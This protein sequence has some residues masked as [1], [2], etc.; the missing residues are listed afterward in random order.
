MRRSGKPTRLEIHRLKFQQTGGKC[1][2]LR[3]EQLNDREKDL[4]N[5][6]ILQDVRVKRIDFTGDLDEQIFDDV[7]SRVLAE[8]GV[9]C[10]HPESSLEP[11]HH[12]AAMRCNVCEALVVNWAFNKM[13]MARATK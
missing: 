8:F 10:N 7:Q 13:N 2:L 4:I 1:H 12:K 9:M 11:S 5:Q 3:L 6:E